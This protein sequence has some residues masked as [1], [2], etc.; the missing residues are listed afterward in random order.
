M[1]IDRRTFLAA[2]A[3]GLALTASR[4]AW[5]APGLAAARFVINVGGP[6]TGLAALSWGPLVTELQ[7]R[8][9]PTTIVQ[10]IAPNSSFTDNETR[11]AGIVAALRDVTEPVVIVGISNEGG[12]LPLVAAARPV[13]RLVY[14][15]ACIPQPGRAFIEV[16]STEPF[17]VPDSLLDKLIKGA[18]PVT[19]EF[20]K[21]RADPDVTAA[22]RQTFRDHVQASK[23]AS[24][25]K[26]FYEVCT[27][28]QM[29]EV[30][31]VD[32]SGAAD[33]Q[34]R[35][36]WEQAAARRM[37]KVEP[38]VIPGAAHA[39]IVITYAAQVADAAVRGL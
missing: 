9:F 37:L 15:N 1:P 8:G 7:K 16:A 27:L 11:A 2:G 25:M 22:Q 13:K 10:G 5:A 26:N 23:Y 28:T 31:N 35:P 3:A 29:P 38:V 14:V 17:A 18:Q 20:L 39:D 12:Y 32:I 24:S 36:A 21:L 30:E 34:I 6:P 33:D 4:A 19:D